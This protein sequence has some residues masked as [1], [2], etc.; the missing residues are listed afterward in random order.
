MAAYISGGMNAGSAAQFTRGELAAI[1]KGDHYSRDG[2]GQWRITPPPEALG[3]DKAMAK[4]EEA[5]TEILKIC[6]ERAEKGSPLNATPEN[7]P[8]ATSGAGKKNGLER[9]K[10]Y[11][12]RETA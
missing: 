5:L 6:E 12:R 8:K 10:N 2:T 3:I 11:T 9:L 4:C 7:T 1:Y